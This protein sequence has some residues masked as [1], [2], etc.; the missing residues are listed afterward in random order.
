M[1]HHLHV[2]QLFLSLVFCIHQ[3]FLFTQLT[4]KLLR[5]C[6]ALA[7][8]ERSH[9]IWLL[10]NKWKGV[11]ST[12]TV[13]YLSEISLVSISSQIRIKLRHPNLIVSFLGGGLSHVMFM[14]WSNFWIKLK[15][16]FII[17]QFTFKLFSPCSENILN[18][19]NTWRSFY[20]VLSESDLLMKAADMIEYS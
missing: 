16:N 9:P 1:K 2:L 5:L 15:R 11:C 19:Y 4:E 3:G 13:S 20:Y 6:S 14:M 10:T 7:L 17:L 8:F 18:L 12:T